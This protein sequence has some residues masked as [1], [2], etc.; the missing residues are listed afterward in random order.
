MNGDLKKKNQF[1]SEFRQGA[2]RKKLDCLVGGECS[3]S[4]DFIRVRLGTREKQPA[5]PPHVGQG[6]ANHASIDYKSSYWGHV[7]L[8]I[9][10]K[11]LNVGRHGVKTEK[12]PL[13]KRRQRRPNFLGQAPTWEGKDVG[14]DISKNNL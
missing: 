14:F 2:K 10:K 5:N 11:T 4:N 9:K 3:R 7:G 6:P 12:E 13:Q 1:L 8:N